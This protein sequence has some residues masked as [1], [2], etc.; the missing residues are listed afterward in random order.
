MCFNVLCTRRYPCDKTDEN[1][2][3]C[4]IL[5]RSV[6]SSVLTNLCEVQYQNCGSL[7]EIDFE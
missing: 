6:K 3:R 1:G 2:K 7:F 5:P 4:E